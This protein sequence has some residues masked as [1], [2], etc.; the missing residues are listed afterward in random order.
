MDIWKSEEVPSIDQ[1]E[2][3]AAWFS[4]WLGRP[5]RLV[6]LAKNAVRTLNP[7]YAVSA[8]DHTGFADGFPILLICS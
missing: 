4:D 1:G 6:H 8:E 7:K 3:A 5:V 2:E